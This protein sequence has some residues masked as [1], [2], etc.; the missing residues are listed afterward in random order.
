[1]CKRRSKQDIIPRKTERG[2]PSQNGIGDTPSQNNEGNSEPRG[3]GRRRGAKKLNLMSEL[4]RGKS[5]NCWTTNTNR[6]K[7][8][9]KPDRS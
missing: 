7:G 9:K 4:Y 2:N 5:R 1:M 3:H 8:M 6:W